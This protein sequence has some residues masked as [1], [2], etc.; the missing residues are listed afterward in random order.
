VARDVSRCLHAFSRAAR[1]RHLYRANNTV[2]KRMMSDL[3]TNITQLLEEHGELSLKI[4]PEAI[5]YEDEVVLEEPNPDESIPFAFYRDGIRRLDLTQGLEEKELEVLVSATADG[6]A[7]SGLGDDIVSFLWRHD[8][9]HV[10]YMVVDTS[11]VDVAR[12]AAQGGTT[13]VFDLD[14]QIE[15]LLATIYGTSATDDVG[16]RTVRVDASDLSA[17]AIADTLDS[18][19][20][21]APGFHPARALAEPPVYAA[22]MLAELGR[23][24]D[25]TIIVR[26]VYEAL[27]AARTALD[28]DDLEHTFEVLLRLYDAA[29]VS[30]SYEIAGLIISG[31]RRL[32]ERESLRERT[33]Q[34]IDEAIDEARLRQISIQPPDEPTAKSIDQFF[35]ACGPRA[36]PAIL[37]LIP[38]I[39]DPARRHAVSDLAASI[40]IE[41]LDAVRL[42]LTNEQAFVAMEAVHIL[43]RL[44]SFEAEE[45]LLSAQSHP[46]APVRA[47]LLSMADGFSKEQQL[48]LAVQFLEDTELEVKIAACQ[49]LT[50][51]RDV[52]ALRAIEAKVKAPELAAAAPPLKQALLNA[53]TSLAQVK[54]LPALA[55][56]FTDGGGLLSKKDAEE[57]AIAAARCLGDL[58]TPGAIQALK[59]AATFLNLKVRDA[60]QEALR[61]AKTKTA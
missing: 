25:R 61:R 39:A 24:D 19:D 28:G 53:Y 60:A 7:Y 56:M 31:V 36:V 26:A 59:K 15:G 45:L 12:Q 37:G 33:N 32:P 50:R 38:S 48:L 10:R 44:G 8:L 3:T 4:R 46:Q 27:H 14:A 5:L 22:D 49:L 9:E 43:A 17:K 30:T 23:E 35:T 51:I 58:G 57:L 1:A 6:Y 13:E 34:W 52:R 16:P 54:A 2:L 47:A 40:G 42:L 29:L 55:K 41:N 11:I 18:V 21:M 20:E